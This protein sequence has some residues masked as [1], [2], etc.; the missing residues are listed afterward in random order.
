M[1]ENKNYGTEFRKR[2]FFYI[3]TGFF[4]I[5]LSQ[6]F[7]TQIIEHEIFDEKS[8]DNSIKGIVQTPLRGVFYD[9]NYK[10]LVNNKPSYTVLVSPSTY[11]KRLNPI[12]ET[13]LGV[14]AGYIDEVLANNIQYSKYIPVR[15]QRDVTFP[16]IAWIEENKEEL[17]GVSYM[18][19]MERAYP[20]SI[21]A[22]HMFGYTKEISRK[23]MD[24]EKGYY[25][26]GDF[27]GNNGIEHTYEK[28]L[29]G[30]K[31]VRY[32]LVDSRRR[33]NG[34]FKEGKN[35]K[36][37]IKGSDLVLS[38]DEDAQ[39]V[40]EKGFKNFVGAL[41]AIEPKTGE[42]LAFVSS[43][44]YDLN[45]FTV[46]TPREIWKKMNVDPNKPLINRAT[47]SVYPPGSTFK[48]LCAIAGLEEGVI[49][50]NTVIN[51]PGGFYFGRFFKCHG[52]VHGGLTVEHAIEKS[53]NTFFYSLI[54]RVG[55]DKWADYA[56]RFGFGK[57]TGIDITEENRGILPSTQWYDKHYGVNK[58]T[59]GYVVSLGIGQGEL[60][61]T[62]VQLAHYV[63]MIAN[64]GKSRRPHIVKGYLDND[65][66]M[67]PFT[68]EET[69]AHISRKTMDIVK[70][71]MF[72]VV[73]G[74]G[75]ASGA[76]IPGINVAGKTGTAQ[77]SHGEDH[78]WFIGFA[79][80]E[81]PKIAVAVLVE[82]A[83]FGAT[84]AMPI[85]KSVIEAYLNKPVK[86]PVQK[87]IKNG[88]KIIAA[89]LKN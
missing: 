42:V 18:V 33:E 66:K 46:V 23:Q 71:G 19:E 58:W 81:D 44:T 40:A 51:C 84:W 82:N 47:L 75:T 48:P 37:S 56:G 25:D 34:R 87:D 86:A 13:V 61:V 79:P 12:I 9:R 2:V 76:K 69:D 3:L 62:P 17:P 5:L 41:V 38:V 59:Q 31:G 27:V 20:D 63:A 55:L 4:C 16:A 77:N 68:F 88:G 7:R 32:I 50:E 53:C 8:A 24:E 43:P 70:R 54:L 10:L 85:A 15:I 26:M 80:F 35:D 73:N 64:N 22:S 29:R 11:Q 57:K 83:G 39:K 30:T 60:S 21:S 28:Y 74:A 6:L 52:G 45:N 67:V 49:N 72:L 1:T 89:S 14:S 65:K 78:A 36:E